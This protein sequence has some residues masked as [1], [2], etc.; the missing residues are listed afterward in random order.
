MNLEN[1][2]DVINFASGEGL[3]AATYLMRRDNH[4]QGIA[5]PINHVLSACGDQLR[6]VLVQQGG[7]QTLNLAA[8]SLDWLN[9]L[10]AFAIIPI[11]NGEENYAK[12]LLRF[13]PLGLDSHD[14]SVHAEARSEY[15]PREGILYLP[16]RSWQ[17][18][19]LKGAI[20]AAEVVNSVRSG[21]ATNHT[22][23]SWKNY[24]A[25]RF[26]FFSEEMKHAILSEIPGIL[27]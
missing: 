20:I 4:R 5:A 19:E 25:E 21:S 16:E 13:A 18:H 2:E 24:I 27:E 17:E 3:L 14:M 23:T 9:K 11:E 6:V 10:V 26:P 12:A 22:R 8:G 7:H 15:I 1:M